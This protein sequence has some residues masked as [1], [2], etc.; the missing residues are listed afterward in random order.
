MDAEKRVLWL[1]TVI[2]A[3]HNTGLVHKG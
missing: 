2:N 3:A 1:P